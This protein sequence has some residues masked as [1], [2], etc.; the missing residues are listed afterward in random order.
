MKHY[1]ITLPDELAVR[2]KATGNLS[3]AIRQTMTRYQTLLACARADLREILTPD[4]AALLADI[5]N[6]TL[7]EPYEVALHAL[8][9]EAEDAEEGYYAKWGVTR[10]VLLAKLHSLSPLQRAALIDAIERFWKAAGSG[11]PIDARHLLA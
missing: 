4:E 10:H 2:L 7:F 6:G 8:P 3:E 1:N 5:C 11:I 9:V